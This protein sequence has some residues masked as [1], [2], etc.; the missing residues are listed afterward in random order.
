MILRLLR[1]RESRIARIPAF[2]T[3]CCAGL[4]WGGCSTDVVTEEELHY[5][6]IEVPF[7]A[8]LKPDTGGFGA[9]PPRQARYI[10]NLD[11]P[12]EVLTDPARR[13]FRVDE[14]FQIRATAGGDSVR[15]TSWSARTVRDVTLEIYLQD[16]DLYV[17]VARMDSIPGFGQ[18]EFRPS[19]VGQRVTCETDK[20]DFISFFCRSFDPERLKPR[21]VS[22]DGHF[23][24]LQ[25]IDARWSV[26]F[27][28][29]SLAR[30]SYAE[31]SALYAREWVV[32]LTNFAYL[33]TTPEYRHLMQAE[34][35][36]KVFGGDLCGNDRQPFAPEKYLSEAERFK[37]PMNFRCGRSSNDD[38]NSGYGGGG[39]WLIQH[40]CFYGHYASFSGWEVIAH[41]F[42]HN[43]GYGHESNMTYAWGDVGYTSLIWQLHIYLNTA[44]RLPYT[45]R[46]LLGFHKL[47]NAPYRD[48]GIRTDF[49]DDATLEAEIRRFYDKSA[50][51]RYFEENPLTE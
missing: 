2:L 3:A 27:T 46:N 39:L 30:E 5:N 33:M 24:M 43:M 28:N 4:L 7:E 18:F 41:E 40:F 26:Q 45:D 48:G 49:L 11:E 20:G 8:T 17:P 10:L 22:D 50:V 19:F 32:I 21:L 9:L 15:I 38:G 36:R 6:D 34:N 47:E 12:A 25:Q 1:R 31:C 13:S 37:A 35:F 14:L 23:R 42:M 44:G 16:F 29:G 51:V